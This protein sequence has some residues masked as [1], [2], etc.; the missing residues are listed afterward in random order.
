[1]VKIL[2]KNGYEYFTQYDSTSKTFEIFL[3]PEGESYIGCAD[4]RNECIAI[5]KNHAEENA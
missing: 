3:D 5:A 2:T 4:T 1:M